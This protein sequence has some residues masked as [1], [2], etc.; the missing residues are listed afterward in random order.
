[1][2]LMS[3]ICLILFA[4]ILCASVAM[5][6]AAAELAADGQA[7]YEKRCAMCHGEDGKGD[8]KAGK[9]MKTPDITTADWKEGTSVEQLVATLKKGL[10]KMKSFEGKVSDEELT[11]A[12]EYTRQLCGK[13]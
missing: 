4:A 2:S 1:M 12:A 3:K 8:T 11:A 7:V 5:S 6:T 9:M 13:E 10:G